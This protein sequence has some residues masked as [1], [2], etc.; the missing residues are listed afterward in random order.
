MVTRVKQDFA[1]GE[2]IFENYGQTNS[3]YFTMHGFSIEPN[4][5]NCVDIPVAENNV[6]CVSLH[7]L[8]GIFDKYGNIAKDL[9]DA[10]HV[11][12]ERYETSLEQDEEILAS[13]TASDI[14]AM[15][16]KATVKFRMTEK[17]LLASVLKKLHEIV[18]HSE[19]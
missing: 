14:H 6:I 12:L 11:H 16:K 19:L 1:A 10:I 2:Q 18:N 15:R 5:F 8:K 7:R 9:I 4:E 17:R 13:I 3:N